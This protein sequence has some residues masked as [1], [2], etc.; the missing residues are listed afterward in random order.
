MNKPS[1]ILMGSKPGSVLAL[2]IM[3]ER[4]WQVKYVVVSRKI[5]HP[6]VAGPTLEEYATSQGIKV[7]TQSQL[8]RSEKADF[9]I[10][11]M[12]RYMVKPDVIAMADRAALNFHAGPL[13]EFG[14]WAFY[15]IA[16][17]ENSPEYG[18]TCHYLDDGFDT[19]PLFKVN[20]FPI[21]ASKETA[22][23]LE[24]KAQENMIGLF[25]DFC[26]M[27]ESGDELPCI[28]QDRSKMRYMQQK[29]F[30]KLKEIPLD[31]DTET[32]ER[33]ARAFWYPPY[34]C[35][36]VKL[37]NQKVDVIPKIAKEQIATLLHRNDFESLKNAAISH[38]RRRHND[39]C[40]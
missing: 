33:Y 5:S 21:D 8:P 38:K 24:K 13:P 39:N 26:D 12:F 35:A 25:V 6:W 36:Y 29:D 22:V 40:Q 32:I 18:C 10:S 2:S 4:G 19:G 1:A 16:V 14:G 37:N 30:M 31:A 7:V 15:S 20:R 27:A 3:I 23:S 9:I 28:K 11:Y 17:L 34:E